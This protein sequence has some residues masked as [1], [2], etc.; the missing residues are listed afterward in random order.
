[1]TRLAF[2]FVALA[3]TAQQGAAPLAG[4][5]PDPANGPG[6]VTPGRFFVMNRDPRTEAVPVTLASSL[7]TVRVAS[8]TPLQVTPARQPWEYRQITVSAGWETSG[9]TV[10]LQGGL[11][12]VLKRPR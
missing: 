2:A 12:I 7:D 9:V 4:T 6:R 5:P 3:A 11:L 1:M 10:P 8:A